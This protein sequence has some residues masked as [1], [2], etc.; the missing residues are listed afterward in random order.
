MK[1]FFYL[2]LPILFLGM[3]SCSESSKIGCTPLNKA[4]TETMNLHNLSNWDQSVGQPSLLT[5][6]IFKKILLRENL[7]PHTDYFLVSYEL[8][9]GIDVDGQS[10]RS[11][12]SKWASEEGD[13]VSLAMGVFFYETNG[14]GYNVLGA[15]VESTQVT[16]TCKCTGTCGNGCEVMPTSSDEWCRCSSC[17]EQNKNCTKE[18]SKVTVATPQAD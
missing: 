7:L 14:I 18:H 13:Y 8:S 6:E 11:I 5:L 3:L 17:F 1:K 15:S 12:N 9:E 4:E 10:I 2:L 16:W